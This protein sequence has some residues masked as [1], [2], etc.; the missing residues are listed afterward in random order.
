M[1]KDKKKRTL[2]ST[3]VGLA[4]LSVGM[5]SYSNFIAPQ[6]AENNKVTIYVANQ[7]IPANTNL[8]EDM[9]KT[10]SINKNSYVD[11][12]V[13]NVREFVGKQLKGKLESGE[14]LSTYRLSDKLSKEGPLIAELR[15]G[16]NIPL[17]NNDV[18]R[19]YV[20]HNENGKV[21]VEELFH[22]KQVISESVLENN[23]SLSKQT[24]KFISSTASM[25]SGDTNRI[26][27]RL[28]DKEAMK[29]QEAVNT[30]T[31]YVAKIE[32]EESDATLSNGI[33]VSKYDAKENNKETNNG[34]VALYEVQQGDTISSIAEKFLTSEKRIASLNN[35]KTEFEVGEKIQVP[36]N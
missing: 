12:S 9:F 2:N 23:F 19:V 14:I 26:Y 18:I 32:D 31:L 33:K 34:S 10:V 7:D 30:G 20:Q 27:V 25:D 8:T 16:T 15:I 35:G 29:Y 11:G 22:R 28:T 36:G 5:F 1:N 24:N 3:L 13:T 6:I 4:A 21:V 17:H